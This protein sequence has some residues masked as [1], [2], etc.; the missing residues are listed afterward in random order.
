[1]NVAL[2]GI[3]GLSD[4]SVA[5]VPMLSYSFSDNIEIYACLNFNLGKEGIVFGT[6]AGHGRLIRVRI[7][8]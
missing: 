8:F 7:Y 2:I 1:M 5:L 4:N 6:N 3:A